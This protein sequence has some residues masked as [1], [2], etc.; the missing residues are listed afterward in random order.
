MA[1][2]GARGARGAVRRRRGLRR[3]RGGR[4]QRR[5]DRGADPDGPRPLPGDDR[6]HGAD[7]GRRRVDRRGAA[8]LGDLRRRAVQPRERYPLR[9]RAGRHPAR[10]GQA[11]TVAQRF[12]SDDAIKVVVGPAGSPEVEAV[13]PVFTRGDLAFVSQSAT[14]TDLTT[15]GDYP[16]F[17]RVVPPDSVQGPTIA[18][19]LTERLNAR[20]VFI[21]D[22]QSSLHG[23]GRER[24]GRAYA[25][26]GA[27]LARVGP[28]GAD[29]LLVA[30]LAGARRRRLRLP[31]L[32]ARRECTAV[33]TPALRARQGREDLRL[34]RPLLPRR[35]Q[36]ERLARVGLRTRHHERAG[37][38]GDRDR[39]PAR[40]RRLR[41]VRA[42]D[43]R[44]HPGRHGGRQGCVWRIAGSDPRAGRRAGAAGA[45]VRDDPRLP[46]RIRQQGRRA[47]RGVLRVRGAQPQ[48]RG[49]AAAVGGR[50]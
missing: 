31:A 12:V 20:R 45:P 21:I 33:R 8:Q 38:A 48:V 47:Q 42:A 25:R 6:A 11:S 5:R 23:P 28:P 46:D 44:R 22:D 18:T 37:V 30:G 29:G 3:R 9:A 24:R 2:R 16:T 14:A 4:R 39:L 13:G 43:L 34:R 50:G 17:S 26:A 7:H 36:L 41:H 49:G 19:Y 32:A 15:G 1:R 27:G 40:Q 35:L 10:S